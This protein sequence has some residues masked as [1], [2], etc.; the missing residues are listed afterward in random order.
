MMVNI[1]LLS[2]ALLNMLWLENGI[3]Y[4]DILIS[5]M[6]FVIIVAI[7]HI[8]NVFLR[9]TAWGLHANYMGTMGEDYN[10]VIGA[11]Y[12]IIPVS[13]V[14]L[15]PLIAL[16]VGVQFLTVLPFVNSQN[17]KDRQE[18]LEEL[19][20]LGNMKAQQEYRKKMK[21]KSQ[22][23]L[24]SDEKAT[25][26]HTKNV[27]NRQNSGFVSVTKEVKTNNEEDIK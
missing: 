9:F 27:S 10:L 18:K 12:K 26:G 22:I 1:S 23:L 15:L 8:I 20:A 19:V 16:L 6:D 24:R 21:D 11:L 25:P 4:K 2:Y 13:F 17:L 5:T 3:E 14:E 7:V